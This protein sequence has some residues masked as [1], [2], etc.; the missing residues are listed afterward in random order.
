[1]RV[2]LASSL[3]DLIENNRA[4]HAT[5]GKSRGLC[6][7]ENTVMSRNSSQHSEEWLP[8]ETK[9]YA[10]HWKMPLGAQQFRRPDHMA[11]RRKGIIDSILVLY[12]D[13]SFLN[14][15]VDLQIDGDC[16]QS[17]D[18][19]PGRPTFARV[20]SRSPFMWR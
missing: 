16:Y 4:R 14:M 6:K 10:C 3:P 7:N 13:Y 1:M 15:T 5:S 19:G 20:R 9:F 8:M 11:R 2:T 17:I 18:S 12:I